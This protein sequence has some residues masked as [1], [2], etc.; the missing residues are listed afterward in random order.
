MVNQE[1]HQ[2]RLRIDNVNSRV[3]HCRSVKDWIRLWKPGVRHLVMEHCY[4]LHNFR[5]R[6][7]PGRPMV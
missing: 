4:A 5:V 7:T 6:L 1:R 3:K 2:R